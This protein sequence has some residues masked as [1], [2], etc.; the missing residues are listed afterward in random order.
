[1]SVREEWEGPNELKNFKK[2][3]DV[4]PIK[5]KEPFNGLDY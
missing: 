3:P 1:M 5:P 4:L 2:V